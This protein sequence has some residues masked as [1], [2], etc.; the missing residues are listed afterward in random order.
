MNIFIKTLLSDSSSACSY[1]WI[2]H[3]KFKFWTISFFN[4]F[5]NAAPTT[6]ILPAREEIEDSSLCNISAAANATA[7]TIIAEVSSIIFVWTQ[8]SS[9]RGTKSSRYVRFLEAKNMP[10]DGPSYLVGRTDARVWTIQVIEGVRAY[11]RIWSKYMW[12]RKSVRPPANN[13][14]GVMLCYLLFS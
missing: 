7:W 3:F 1:L 10:V 13:V 2:P 6:A 8:I 11:P 12:V 5:I 4:F 14:G 9:V